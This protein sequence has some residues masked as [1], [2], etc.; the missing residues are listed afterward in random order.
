[1]SKIYSQRHQRR[2]RAERQKQFLSLLK[3]GKISDENVSRTSV[4]ELQCLLININY[5][6][7]QKFGTSRVTS[8]ADLILK[9]H[10]ICA[11]V[12]KPS[13]SIRKNNTEKRNFLEPQPSVSH[14]LNKQSDTLAT[15]T[16]VLKT[17]TRDVVNYH[18]N[19]ISPINIDILLPLIN[20]SETKNSV[21]AVEKGTCLV[22]EHFND[23]DVSKQVGL[24]REIHQIC[25]DFIHVIP[26]N[27]IEELMVILNKYTEAPFPKRAQTLLGTSLASEIRDILGGEYCH[28]GVENFAK[29]IARFYIEHEY[30]SDDMKLIFFVD[31]ADRRNSDKGLWLILCSDTKSGLVGPIGIFFGKGKPKNFNDFLQPF[32]D[33]MIRLL[34]EGITVD[35]KIFRVIFHALMCDTPALSYVLNTKGHAGYDS[36]PKCLIHGKQIIL[37][38]KKNGQT[39]SKVCFLKIH[40]TL[41]NDDDFRGYKYLGDYQNGHTIL[42]K[43]PKLG[44]VSRIAIDYMHLVCLGVVKLLITIWIFNAPLKKRLTIPQQNQLQNAMDEIHKVLPSCFNKPMDILKVAKWKAHDF[45]QFLLYTG[46]VVLKGLL[47][48]EFYNNFVTLSLAIRILVC[49]SMCRKESNLDYAQSLTTLFVKQF[50]KLYGDKS[51]THN[52]HCLLHLT[53]DV[54]KFGSLDEFGA[55]K[56]ENYIGKITKLLRKG[57]K[58]LQQIARRLGELEYNAESE[59]KEQVIGLQLRDLRLKFENN[60]ENISLYNSAITNSFEVNCLKEGDSYVLLKNDQVVRVVDFAFKKDKFVAGKNC[61]R[62]DNLYI[63]P[64]ESR[65]F[66]INIC[67]D[68]S[69]DR[70]NLFSWPVTQIK[71]K[72]CKLSVKGRSVFLPILHTYNV[73][74]ITQTL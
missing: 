3:R 67:E 38:K 27:F 15:H 74:A 29:K 53:D 20:Q 35:D 48:A 4:A 56:F 46:P 30:C 58:P 60:G 21:A 34:Q 51:M 55:F 37:G 63:L 18:Q 12:P 8:K 6:S 26:H 65:L 1:M 31:G 25:L 70:Q 5:A 32:T 24:M 33:E 54:R 16:D 59:K 47:C 14:N 41:R 68:V 10:R 72:V 64:C 73:E 39:N 2:L 50:R 61:N 62:L 44:L 22:T 7:S 40:S 52:I 36:C 66:N 17:L 11:T 9:T 69:N 45:R 28:Y 43:I 19:A 57:E 49:P 42:T 23:N 13:F 71:S